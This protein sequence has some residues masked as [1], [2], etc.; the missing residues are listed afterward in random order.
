MKNELKTAK[1][2]IRVD[3]KQSEHVQKICFEN[4][5]VWGTSP[6][7]VQD[8]DCPYLYIN[9]KS[10]KN[11]GYSL[12]LAQWQGCENTE[13][14][15][16]DFVKKYEKKELLEQCLSCG[17]VRSFKASKMCEKCSCGAF[18]GYEKKKELILTGYE[19]DYKIITTIS[20]LDREKEKEAVLSNERWVM[21]KDSG[22]W[23]WKRRLLLFETACNY[24]CVDEADEEQF[25]LGNDYG[26]IIWD[27]MKEIE[28]PKKIPHDAESIRKGGFVWIR[29]LGCEDVYSIQ[30]LLENQLDTAL[31]GIKY[32]DVDKYE[33]AKAGGD[34]EPFYQIKK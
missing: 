24:H 33:I 7:T 1:L 22:D 11:L 25:L 21:V 31:F 16:E 28:E 3:P 23:A 10:K 17:F 14:T 12:S 6:K 19:E 13:I 15:Y 8:R 4:G 5:V 20:G 34:F 9:H 2:K 29:D 30:H 32:S 18:G 27:I 26:V